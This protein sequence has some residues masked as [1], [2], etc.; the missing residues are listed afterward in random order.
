MR[1]FYLAYPSE[2]LQQPAADSSACAQPFSFLQQLAANL[3]W[4]HV[5]V[6]IEKVKDTDLRT[7]YAESVIEH[8]WSRA[9]LIHQIDTNLH[10]RQGKAITNFAGQLPAPQSELAQQITKDP[11]IFDFL[12]LTADAKEKELHLGLVA[13]VQK[14]LL[15]LGRGFAFVGSQY[16]VVVEGHDYY[17]DLLFYHTLLHCYVVIDL[18]VDDFKPEYAGKMNFYLSAVDNLV[19]QPLDEPSIGMI[20]CQSRNKTVVEYSLKDSNKPVGVAE[21]V[22]TST[23]DENLRGKLV[24]VD[25][26]E[27]YLHP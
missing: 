27:N 11:Y 26:L 4:G 10:K 17:I 21:W 15:E 16:H 5:T 24:M 9:I 3:P 13:S 6:L 20:I 7:W 8:G 19:K 1:A 25:E 22:V 2:T 12:T 23:L 18:K 14:M